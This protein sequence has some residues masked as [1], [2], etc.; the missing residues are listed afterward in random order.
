MT[1][2]K[3]A[4]A[5]S[6]LKTRVI[7]AAVLAPVIVGILLF[8]GVPF[9]LLMLVA[10]GIS[11]SEW[12]K[13]V[14]PGSAKPLL[15]ACIASVVLPV[16]VSW[17]MGLGMAI[18]WLFCLGLAVYL[19]ARFIAKAEHSVRVAFG[20][21]YLGLAFVSTLWLRE[22]PDGGLFAILILFIFIWATDILAYFSGKTI[23][24]PK[25]APKISPKKTWAGLIGGMVGSAACIRVS[26]V[27]F[28]PASMGTLKST[29]IKTRF[30]FRFIVSM[31]C[32]AILRPSCFKALSHETTSA[33]PAV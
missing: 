25:L 30:P 21:F 33:H 10:G 15:W 4:N 13:M 26:S 31:N 1:E 14:E 8:G 27:T 2:N 7:S 11:A 28:P 23:G 19:Y 16:L 6:S 17:E 20:V 18:Y 3:P 24:G 5:G 9:L 22:L 12:T 32:T 29:R